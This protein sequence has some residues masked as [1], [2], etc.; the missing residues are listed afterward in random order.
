MDN[1]PVKGMTFVLWQGIYILKNW[2]EFEKF[3]NPTIDTFRNNKTQK[4]KKI[5]SITYTSL[6]TKLRLGKPPPSGDF[7]SVSI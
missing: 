3:Y 6:S 7:K 4:E 5:K 2:N 1:V